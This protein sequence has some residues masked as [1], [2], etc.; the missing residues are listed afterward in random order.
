MSEDTRIDTADVL[1]IN[2]KVSR[3]TGSD[4]FGITTAGFIPK[5]FVRL[6]AEKLALARELFGDELDLTSGS[7]IRKLLEV[8]ALEDARTWSA[9]AAMYDN[10]FVASDTG[11]A[12][13]RLG[14]ELGISRPFLEAQGKN[15][16]S[17]HVWQNNK[18]IVDQLFSSFKCIN[19]IRKQS[20]RIRGDFQLK[21]VCAACCPG[22]TQ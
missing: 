6:L 3:A 11:D 12:L 22:T 17:I 13:S 4:Q 1:A 5:P 18:T 15:R 10:S 2:A 9:L 7:S 20:A 16:I 19:R 8:S 14:E 21:P